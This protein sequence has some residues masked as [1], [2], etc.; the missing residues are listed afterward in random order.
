VLQIFLIWFVPESP[1]WLVSKGRDAQALK[2]LAYYHAD[3]DEDDPLVQFEYQEIKAQIEFDRSVASDV[4]YKS[5]FTTP[6]NLYECQ[7]VRGKTRLTVL[8]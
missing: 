5:L 2:T 4:S 1:R 3:G 8:S 6:G 7:I